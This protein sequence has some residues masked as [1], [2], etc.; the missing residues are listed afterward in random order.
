MPS[1]KSYRDLHDTVTSRDG[2]KARLAVLRQETLTEIGLYELRRALDRSQTDV[3]AALG[4]SQSAVS[5][6]EHADD[7]K[8]STLR[9]YVEGLGADLQLLAV[10][11]DGEDETSIPISVG[12]EP[13]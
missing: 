11:D 3:A 6:L 13:T 4:I 10:F 7:L 5:Q 1:T 8:I 9:H 12:T 2:A